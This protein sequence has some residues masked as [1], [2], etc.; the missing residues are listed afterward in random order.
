MYVQ[1]NN[2][3]RSCNNCCGGRAV[4]ITYSDCVFA[5]IGIQHAMRMRHV[6]CGVPGSTIFFHVIS[7]TARFSEKKKKK[8]KKRTL[9]IKCVFWFSLQLLSETFLTPTRTEWNVITNVHDSSCYSCPILMTLEL[10]R[11]TFGRY[12]NINPYPANVKNMVSY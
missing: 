10:Y 1:R 9:N 5:A 6:I 11:Q 8:K 7:Q 4:N 3:A 2:E 12:S